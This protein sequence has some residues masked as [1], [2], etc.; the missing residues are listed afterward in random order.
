MSTFR[1]PEERRPHV[2][3]GR[4]TPEQVPTFVAIMTVLHTEP[5]ASAFVRLLKKELRADDHL[6]LA[7]LFEE[8]SVLALH[9]H[10]AEELLFDAFAFDMYWD[11]L[12]E[13]VLNVRALEGNEKFC[14]NF[15]IAAER[16]R[17]YRRTFPPKLRWQRRRPPGEPPGPGRDDG[18]APLRPE[19]RGPGGEHRPLPVHPAGEPAEGRDAE[20]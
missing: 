2:D 11:E 3:F 9:R 15:E 17:E 5:L 8:V 10:L 19:G 16:A 4:S 20:G 13:D 7:H 1:R 12:R 6:H 14:E 18:P